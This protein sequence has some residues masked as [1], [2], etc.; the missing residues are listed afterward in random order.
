LTSNAH[1]KDE[2]YCYIFDTNRDAAVEFG[3]GIGYFSKLKLEIALNMRAHKPVP[4]PN[5]HSMQRIID[6][7]AP[8]KPGGLRLGTLVA[9]K[10]DK[11][12][13]TP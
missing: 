2:E 3:T 6:T 10:I 7:A 11:L 1:K 5:P 9:F 8:R 13:G 4:P 12:K